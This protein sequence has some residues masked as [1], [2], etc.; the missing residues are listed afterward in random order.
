M[1][2]P[3]IDAPC[4]PA[5]SALPTEDLHPGG[6]GHR[7]LHA[8]TFFVSPER[9]TAGT[10]NMACQHVRIGFDRLPYFHVENMTS[11]QKVP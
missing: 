10:G 8:S 2:I 7:L 1:G 9:V 4:F 5:A 11:G 6:E 3:F